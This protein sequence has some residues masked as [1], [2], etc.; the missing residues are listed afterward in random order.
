MTEEHSG[1]QGPD[2][3]KV[4]FDHPNKKC[5]KCQQ[6]YLVHFLMPLKMCNIFFFFTYDSK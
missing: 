3:N 5:K 4:I 1:L 2:F 6:F